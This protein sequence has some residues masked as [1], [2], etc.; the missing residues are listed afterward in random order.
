MVTAGSI[1]RLTKN[2]P[3]A[4]VVRKLRQCA[5]CLIDSEGGDEL[6][7]GSRATRSSDQMSGT[8]LRH[9]RG[10]VGAVSALTGRAGPR[11]ME[12]QTTYVG[13][14]LPWQGLTVETS[15]RC[16]NVSGKHGMN[17]HSSLLI[18]VENETFQV[19]N[20]I[21]GMRKC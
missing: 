9:T 16:L 12:A 17:R 2:C 4:A 3:Y 1:F 10:R 7:T 18:L 5:G 20:A 19:P 8:G 11:E 13:K 15:P 6:P 14:V 21:W